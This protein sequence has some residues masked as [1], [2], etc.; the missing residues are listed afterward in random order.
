MTDKTN[1]NMSEFVQSVSVQL[2]HWL[3]GTCYSLWLHFYAA[4]FSCTFPHVVT[5]L[6]IVWV[7]CFCPL[8][9]WGHEPAH[10]WQQAFL[11]LQAAQIKRLSTFPQSDHLHGGSQ[12]YAAVT[13][14]FCSPTFPGWKAPSGSRWIRW[15][16]SCSPCCS[17]S[18]GIGCVDM[19]RVIDRF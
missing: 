7:K 12:L 2:R 4:S 11:F 18:S 13:R 17:H 1:S 16:W 8:W 3:E 15:R 5:V 9:C 14:L 10:L 19:K 6:F